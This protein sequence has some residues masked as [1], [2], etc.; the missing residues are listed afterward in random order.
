[1]QLA[2]RDGDHVIFFE[3]LRTM[4]NFSG[5]NRIGGRLP[6]HAGSTGLVLLAYASDDVVD[7]YLAKPLHRYT[8]HTP[9]SP[10]EIR[11][12]L[13]E[14]RARRYAVTSQTIALEAGSV[15]APVFDAEGEIVVA[16]NA[17][18][19]VQHHDVQ[20]LIRLV[21][22][23]ASRITR[24]LSTVRTPPDPRTVDFNRRQASIA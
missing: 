4:P 6:L 11:A 23:A 9:T 10:E 16:V 20:P 22:T 15:A 12:Q 14:I 17:I 21:L 2:S 24:A 19:F 8:P 5:E 7:A 13:G 1:M 18:Y 3:A